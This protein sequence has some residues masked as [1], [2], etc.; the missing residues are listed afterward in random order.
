MSSFRKSI[1][2]ALATIG[3][4]LSACTPAGAPR[5]ADRQRDGDAA[6]TATDSSAASNRIG[7][8]VV[9][10]GRDV[11]LIHGLG[12]S[13]DVWRETIAAMPG[14]RFHLVQIAGFAGAPAGDN[15]TGPVIA[16]VADAIAAYIADQ[17]LRAPAVIG[18][19]MGGSIGM[20]LARRHPER[21]DR[22]MVVDMVPF[23]GML[24][25]GPAATPASL[26]P[27]AAQVRQRIA[28][29]TPDARR[30][31]NEKTLA[32]MIR[33][34]ARR[35]EALGHAMASDPGVTG[36]GMYDLITTDHRAGLARYRGPLRVLY[37]YPEGAPVPE[38]AYDAF[39]R[40]SFAAVPG[41]TVTKVP[42]SAH[43]IMWDAPDRFRS[44]VKAFLAR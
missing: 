8:E 27:I 16:P 3:L 5:T 32:G 21:V 25:G 38:P 42:D 11:I 29:A 24:F 37:V 20:E 40:L 1:A 10:S 33:T 31:E 15:A 12:S 23:L 18:H 30:V 4:T 7:V 34:T 44:E 36:Q 9:G 17:G 26:E 43:F 2:A 22:L 39:V 13:S 6:P 41:A 14:H 19:S 28:E 35:P